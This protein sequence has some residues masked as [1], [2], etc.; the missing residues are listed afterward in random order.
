MIVFALRHA[1]RA[2][3]G[4][5]ALSPAGQTRAELLAR[6]LRKNHFRLAVCSDAARTRETLAPLTQ[7][8]GLQ[9]TGVGR[10]GPNGIAGHISAVVN[11]LKPLPPHIAAIV[12]GH[13]NTIGPIIKQLC[14]QTIDPIAENEFDK[15]F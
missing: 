8:T 10:N 5:D 4:A 12:V 7:A 1:D 15:L 6:M 14:G 11:M 9:P 13:T 2:E 3:G